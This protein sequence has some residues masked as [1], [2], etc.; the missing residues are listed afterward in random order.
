MKNTALLNRR[1][2]LRNTAL[3]SAGLV[4]AANAGVYAQAGNDYPQEDELV[5]LFSNE[6]PYGPS[7]QAKRAIEQLLHRANRYPT[8]HQVTPQALKEAIAKK[9]GLKPENVVLGHGSYQLL[10]LIAI[11]YG[12]QQ[13]TLVIPRP[14]FNVTGAYADKRLGATVKFIDLDS[15]FRMDLSAMQRA[16]DK[17]T[18]MVM[19]CNPN[20]PTGTVV[21]AQRL[22]D[23]CLE[24]GKKATVFVDEAYIE[25]A[26]PAR[27][28]SMVDLVRQQKNVL[29]TRTFSKMYGLAGMRVGYALARKDIAENLAALN[30]RFGQLLNNMGL[31]SAIASLKDEAFIK[32]SLKKNAEVKQWFCQQL[33]KQGL[34]YVASDTNFVYAQ[35]GKVYAN[36]HSQLAQHHLKAVGRDKSEWSRISLG[37]LG[38]MKK[39]VNSMKTM[40]KV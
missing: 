8:Y 14:T 21:G 11:L 39:L 17:R 37:T 34:P 30:G 3:S 9:E 1:K 32:K 40:R 22:K 24:V 20:N 7:R 4:M 26:D 19:V 18:S 31:A 2:W 10:T 23:F 15:K 36:F 25:Y 33:Q 35:T 27:T 16:V 28:E 13:Q 12:N 5:R 38:D 29:I 6:N